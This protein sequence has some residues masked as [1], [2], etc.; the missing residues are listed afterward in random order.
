MKMANDS[1]LNPIYH[2]NVDHQHVA[3]AETRHFE[4]QKYPP[5]RKYYKKEDYFT[6]DSNL[7]PLLFFDLPTYH[8]TKQTRHK[9]VKSI[10]HTYDLDCV[11]DQHSHGK[12]VG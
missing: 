8:Q 10:C 3:T 9:K 11:D 5:K 2:E 4:M 1:F 12:S 7:G 6:Q